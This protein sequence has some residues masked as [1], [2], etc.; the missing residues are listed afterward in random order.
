M[1]SSEKKGIFLIYIAVGILA[2]IFL[3]LFVIDVLHIS[4]SSME[5]TFK[6]GSKV[7]VNK[8]CYG[9]T[10]PFRGEFLLQWN[11]PERGDIVIYLHDN[12]IVI[13]RCVAIGGDQLEFSQDSKYI[14]KT[15]QE[16][17]P[18]NP[19]QYQ[20][21]KSYSEVPQGYIFALGDNRSDSIDSR[22]Y[23]FVSVKNITGKVI[24]K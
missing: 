23:G 3:K 10:K 20:L 21:M 8:L 18:L 6:S 9:I 1:E 5:P 24:G 15:N 4:G 14:V 12:R 19:V 16:M 11:E 7:C 2:G 17:I 22:D 13:K